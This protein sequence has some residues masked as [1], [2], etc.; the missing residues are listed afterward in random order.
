MSIR[1]SKAKATKAKTNKW[2]YIKLKSFCPAKETIKKMKRNGRKYL[3]IIY[4]MRL[5]SKIYKELIQLNG[6]KKKKK[7]K[8][9][10]F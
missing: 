4:L 7:F 8:Q 9:Y 2:N 6:Q 10:D 5:I 1:F 3:Q